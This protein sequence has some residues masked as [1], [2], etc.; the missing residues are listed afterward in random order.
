VVTRSASKVP[1]SPEPWFASKIDPIKQALVCKV[2]DS[3]QALKQP[4]EIT[5][6]G[7]MPCGLAEAD[8]F[9]YA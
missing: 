8:L 4:T 7:P 6:V 2:K 3:S 1:A 5:R 9:N